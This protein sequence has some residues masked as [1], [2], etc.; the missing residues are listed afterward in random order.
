MAWFNWLFELCQ[1]ELLEFSYE[2]LIGNFD[3]SNEFV[4]SRFAG[5][6]E[7]RITGLLLYVKT[8]A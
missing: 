6:R 7:V 2:S 1:F 5:F 4:R 8:F 3:G